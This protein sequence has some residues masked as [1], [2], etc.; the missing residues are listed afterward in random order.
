MISKKTGKSIG[1]VFG[2]CDG[3]NVYINDDS[4]RL[5]PSTEF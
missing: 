5:S 1:N 4:P 2:F 3:K